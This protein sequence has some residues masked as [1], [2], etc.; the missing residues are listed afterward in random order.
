MDVFP[1]RPIAIQAVQGS[2]KS[3]Q[4]QLAQGRLFAAE[5][6]QLGDGGS[7]ILGVGRERVAATN[8]AGLQVGQ[9]LWLKLRETGTSRL[10]ELVSQDDPEVGAL[11]LLPRREQGLDHPFRLLAQ[12]QGLGELLGDLAQAL[13][14][15]GE[16][17]PA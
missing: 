2:A 3:S 5:V 15:R 8:L 11:T 16:Q 12:G 6:L 14:A 9:K 10:F 4:E 13:A 1:L 17:A 7:V